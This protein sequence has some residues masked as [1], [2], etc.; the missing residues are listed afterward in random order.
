MSERLV[1]L[2]PE[3][4]DAA[5]R[6]GGLLARGAVRNLV[7][8][9]T[10]TTVLSRIVQLRAEYSG[11]ADGAPERFVLKAGLPDRSTTGWKA[12]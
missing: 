1:T 8:E 3:Q 7:V 11:Q 2:G 6:R 5:L 9:S 4:L 10:R 12:A